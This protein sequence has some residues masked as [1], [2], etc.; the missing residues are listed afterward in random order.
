[1]ENN[2]II[3][4]ENPQESANCISKLTFAWI[5]KFL[6]K[7][8]KTDL[9]VKDLYK[10]L[11]CNKSERL[12]NLLEANWNKQLDISQA[13]N[14]KPSLYKA[15]QNTFFWKY[16]FQGM[17]L[18]FYYSILRPVQPV[19]LAVF[20]GL[21]SENNEVEEETRL[22]NMFLYGGL[23]V[24][25]SFI[26]LFFNHHTNLLLAETGMQIRI[27]CCSLLYRK[28]LRLSKTSLGQSS[29]GKIVNL[30]SN[31]VNRFDLVAL[32]LH[33]I[34]IMPIQAVIVTYFIW[35][36]VQI[37]AL[38]GVGSLIILTV[39]VHAYVGKFTSVLRLKIA[40]KTDTRVRVMAEIISGIQVIKMYAW[41]KP[42]AKV[43]DKARIN[44][45]NILTWASYVRGVILSSSVFIERTIL[46]ITVVS[47]VL[48]GNVITADKVFSLAQFF[49]ILQLAMAIHYPLATSFGA[50]TLVTMKRL[51]EFL[52]LEEKAESSVSKNTSK[53]IS[54]TNVTASWVLETKT[55]KNIS[56]DI[57]PGTLCAVIGPVGAGKSSLL[58]L[59]LGEL[60]LDHGNLD[61][62]GNI[63]YSS[64]EPWLFASTVRKNILFGQPY[65][66][67][68]YNNVIKVCALE[69]DFELFPYGDKTLVGEK[70]VSLSGGQKA[71]I[72]LARAVYRDADVYLLDDPL[73]AVD[74]HVGRQLFDNCIVD[75]LQSKTR[76]LVTHQL[77]Y[78]KNA[79]LIIVL[80][81]GRLEVQGTFNELINIKIDFTKLLMAAENQE[82][83]DPKPEKLIRQESIRIRQRRQ[84]VLSCASLSSQVSNYIDEEA[85]TKSENS[86][87]WQY[88]RAGGNFC[89]LFGLLLMLVFGQVTSN[90][91]D[92]W[93]TYWTGQEELRY[94]QCTPSFD[95]VVI[96]G[97]K[98]TEF[99]KNYF[100]F[101]QNETD[102]F[103]ENVNCDGLI[104][105]YKAIYIY[106]GIILLSIIVLVTRSIYYFKVAM[107]SSK[108][109]HNRMFSSLL[110]APMRFFNIN[111][112]GRILNRFSRDMGMIDEILPRFMLEALQIFLVMCG[113]LVIVV[114][115]NYYMIVITIILGI[116]F[117]KI[118]GW[119]MANA[120]DI[121]HLEGIT[122]SP[123]FSHL[124]SSFN[125][126]TTIRSASAE[127]I[128]M[129]EFDLHQDTH[130]SAWYILLV[131][132]EA[133]GLWID[134]LSVTFIAFVIFGFILL[135]VYGGVNG[136]DVGLAIS[137]SLILTGMVQYGMRQTA[138]VVSQ[139]TC[140][141]RV[142]EYTTLEKEGPQETP[143]DKKESLQN[144]PKFGRIIFD[145][146]FLRYSDTDLPVLRNLSFKI[147]PNEKIGIAGRT[148]AGKSSLIS[149]L[150]RL[151]P[152]E[153]NI[154]IDELETHSIALNDLRKKI[155]IIP[156]EPVLF[157]ATLRYNLDPFDEFADDVLWDALKEVELKDVATSLDFDV[158]EGGS[159]FSV[160]Q[161]QLLCLARAI[162][163]NNKILVLDEAT[164]NVDP[165]TD[166]LIQKTIRNKFSSCTVLTIAHRLYT[167]M[168]M[169]KVLIMDAGCMVEY[170]HPYILLQNKDGYLYKMVE[171]TGSVMAAQLH[172][173]AENAYTSTFVGQTTRL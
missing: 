49:N 158:Q 8:T 162:L 163:R 119:Y 46:F 104:D 6:Y 153:G 86:V 106:S 166:A 131:C 88:A 173:V 155:S 125:G 150:F 128:L 9:K 114:A 80:N 115:T 101:T 69:R 44:E 62:G 140:V 152:V 87:Y 138:E 79:D 73:S 71:R 120:R 10:S 76:I 89:V 18:F 34:W 165:Q 33:Y 21:F 142:L 160:G 96:D 60:K 55:L 36:Q 48:F 146:V 19:L 24:L 143:E 3:K 28:L 145:N 47:Y 136:S 127:H 40:Q 147:N 157:S 75:H 84:S 171:Q 82:D 164:A 38:V 130:T 56:F 100:Y 65:E 1:M 139:M 25:T 22:H 134:T 98:G 170:D 137:Q 108:N 141:E 20:I 103:K 78:L 52:L 102:V 132:I 2:I 63:S 148:G 27:A 31:D 172:A 7:G 58:Q 14:T 5:L 23:I 51:E 26:L 91:A 13:K 124:N 17:I 43:A 111:P 161:R 83:T 126:I 107:T 53:G 168:D 105:T 81:E 50:E 123:V 64:Q 61:V 72:N 11:S 159:N 15:I 90:S 45:I 135:H 74:T 167:I 109:L 116:L 85:T 154:I 66:R 122:K 39:P 30:L 94:S 149:A 133:F 16:M 54:L 97:H 93:V 59:L 12:T 144:W 129:K 169:D 70:G 35:Q 92:F 110:Q 57:P 112:T 68:K 118:R 41:E 156:Q 117:Y 95:E 113:I 29:A 4:N 37:A 151:A 121:K 67:H 99:D 77:Q 42:F 32:L